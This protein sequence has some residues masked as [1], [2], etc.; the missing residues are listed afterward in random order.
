MDL[1]IRVQ[2]EMVYRLRDDFWPLAL[3]PLPDGRLLAA[4]SVP[5]GPW[6]YPY[7]LAYGETLEVLAPIEVRQELSR[8]LKKAGEQYEI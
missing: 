1:T 5:W 6:L 7:L 3:E 2:A 8:R 4:L